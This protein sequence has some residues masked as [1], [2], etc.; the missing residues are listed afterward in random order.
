MVKTNLAAVALGTV[1]LDLTVSGQAG[2]DARLS[3]TYPIEIPVPS[4][5]EVLRA[6]IG[7]ISQLARLPMG[8]EQ[9]E[10]DAEATTFTRTVDLRGMSV[11]GALDAL[12]AADP[13]YEWRDTEGVVVMRPATA[14][15]DC[16]H[17]LNRRVSVAW[18]H[19][20]LGGALTM[21][22]SVVNPAFISR[23]KPHELPGARPFSVAVS[24]AT[25]LEA[26]NEVA[27]RGRLSWF[28][29]SRVGDRDG[30]GWIALT[31]RDLD[32]RTE[33]LSGEVKLGPVPC[34]PDGWRH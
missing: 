3:S 26:F 17:F 21:L 10:G 11:R 1:L 8:F 20:P 28:I 6:R 19:L 18:E 25:L 14:W 34:G 12:I 33:G 9:A 15:K 23:G 22:W 32:G 5:G 16:S 30:Q 24:N 29:F 31:L 7:T 27:R 2:L 13:R 4:A